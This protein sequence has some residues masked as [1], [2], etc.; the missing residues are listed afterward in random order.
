M[1]KYSR[2]VVGGF[3]VAANIV[4]VYIYIS[5]IYQRNIAKYILQYLMSKYSRPVVAVLMSINHLDAAKK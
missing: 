1:S 4:A 3:K 5:M 2:P